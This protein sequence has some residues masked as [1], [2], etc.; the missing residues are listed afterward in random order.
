[1]HA[2]HV[3]LDRPDHAGSM[4]TKAS[5]ACSPHHATYPGRIFSLFK[6]ANSC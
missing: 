3:D 2:K 1:M 5:S 6:F 4:Q